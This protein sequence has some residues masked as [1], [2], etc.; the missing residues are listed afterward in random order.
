MEIYTNAL[1]IVDREALVIRVFGY[2]SNGLPGLEIIGLG[3][4]SK[5]IKEKIV[6]LLRSQSLK[7]PLARY[8]IGVETN[9]FLKPES[10]QFLELPIMLLYLV[11]SNNISMVGLDRC[12]CGG[13]LSSN[14]MITEF[15]YLKYLSHQESHYTILCSSNTL[16]S[17]YRT[18]SLGEVF[19]NKISFTISSRNESFDHH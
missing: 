9:R 1:T 3:N 14:R 7:V 10:S 17:D 6:F 5:L 8:V 15:D 16:P 2:T 18:I 4:Y 12:L 11:L 13:H 19:D